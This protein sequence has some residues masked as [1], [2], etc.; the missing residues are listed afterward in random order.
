MDTFERENGMIEYLGRIYRRSRRRMDISRAIG[1]DAE[2]SRAY[3][4]DRDFVYLIDRTVM[5]CSPD[6]RHVIMN[7]YLRKSDSK[8]YIGYYSKSQYYRLRREA[9]KEF[10]HCLQG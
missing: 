7:D 5:D 2:K 3:I 9:V 10:L 6:T 8:W 4:I 1:E